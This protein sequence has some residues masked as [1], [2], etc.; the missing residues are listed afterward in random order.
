MIPPQFDYA[1]PATM[2]EALALLSQNPDAKALAGGHSLLPVMKL[3]LAAP[4]MLIDLRNIAE[5]RGISA[6]GG[7]WRVGAMTTYQELTAHD[8]LRRYH[9]LYDAVSVI[10]DPQVRNRGTIGG[11]LAH[12]DPAADLPAVALALEATIN[13]SGPGGTRAIPIHEFIVGML[14]TTLQEGEIITSIDFPA[15]AAG[16]GS[17]YA[18]FA[19]PASGYAMVGVAARV[20]LSADGTAQQVRVALTGAASQA[21]RL[22][23]VEQA[24][25]G[26]QISDESIAA[27]AQ[28]AGQGLEF[29]GDIHASADYRAAMVKVYARRALASALERA[30]S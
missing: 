19:N 23:E 18:K 4:S 14:E 8:E 25:E 12:N 22:N 15:L 27:A 6:Q 2:N 3:R 29:N 10:G 26:Q 24:L 5:L 7:G 17:A 21:S 20:T 13:T 9:A 30:R 16:T 28:Q 1:A 11:S